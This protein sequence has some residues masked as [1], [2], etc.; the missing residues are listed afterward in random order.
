[1]QPGDVIDGKYRIDDQL[2]EGGMGV[3]HAV[4]HLRLGKRYAIKVLRPAVLSMPGVA[5]RFLREARAAS[6]LKSE[7]VGAVIDFGEIA[8]GEPYIVMERLD[9]EDLGCVL[10]RAPLPPAIAVNYI[11]QASEGLAEA[12]A[13][14]MVHRDIKPA[15][16]FLT[17]RRDGSRLVK[18][19]DFGIATAQTGEVS[20]L[21]ESFSVMGSPF[22]MS[23]EQLRSA[24]I[25]DARSDLWSV[26]V[27]LYELLSGSLPFDDWSFTALAIKIA[28]EP[29]APLTGVPAGL[30]AII[31]RCLE[32]TAD[33]R[34]KDLAQLADALA[35]FT[36]SGYRMAA[37]IGNT[38]APSEVSRPT[39]EMQPLSA[40][41][42][43]RAD[44]VVTFDLDDDTVLDFRDDDSTIRGSPS[45]RATARHRRGV[46]T[47]RPH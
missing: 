45:S 10:A 30:A 35:P 46:V 23:P 20:A 22:Y 33:A 44:D 29:H 9:G 5:Q 7:H 8:T 26:G 24:R 40:V 36:L 37:Q 38:L 28:T 6:Q 41:I 31:D 2:G 43:E 27:T 12:H 18:V 47:S 32:K 16:L 11:L 13:A 17:R 25:V 34:Y 39:G 19:L 4:T 42:F 14:G 15:N 21:T 1:M 3:V